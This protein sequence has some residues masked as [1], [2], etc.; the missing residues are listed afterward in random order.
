MVNKAYF[1][2]CIFAVLI[3]LTAGCARTTEVNS[4]GS[5]SSS[6]SDLQLVESHMESPS[7]PYG[8]G[9][10]MGT[11]KNN[12]GNTYKYVQVTINLYDSSGAQVG[13]TLANI[14]NL[15]PGGTWKFSAPILQKDTTSY[16]VKEITGF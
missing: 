9:N 7:N 11:V 13:S 10:I 3:I 2:L 6:S 4:V 14:N 16:K 15:E 8:Y 5:S 12:G 1:I